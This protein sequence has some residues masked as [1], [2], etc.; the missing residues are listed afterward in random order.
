MVA[1]AIFIMDVKGKVIISRNYRGDI[2]M[3][4]S[5]R[6]TL[7]DYA[8]IEHLLGFLYIFKKKMKWSLDLCSPMKGLRMSILRYISATK[9]VSII[10][11]SIFYLLFFFQC[12]NLLILAVTK[13][14]SNIALILFFLYKLTNVRSDLKFLVTNYI[15]L[16][17]V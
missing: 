12:N 3:S 11:V 1:S 2:P 4:V 17:S 15:L 6:Y 7:V 5:D 9:D 14:N 16:I 8:N 10:F 13:K